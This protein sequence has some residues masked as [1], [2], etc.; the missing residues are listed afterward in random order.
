MT[1]MEDRVTRLEHAVHGNGR[2]GLLERVA[3]VEKMQ[4]ILVVMCLAI[5]GKVFGAL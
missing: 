3:A 5:L 4:Y 1:D 2:R